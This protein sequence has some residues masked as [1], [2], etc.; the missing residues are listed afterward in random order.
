M[1]NHQILNKLFIDPMRLNLSPY[2]EEIERIESLSSVE[3]K[4]YI[5]ENYLESKIKPIDIF[6]DLFYS[7]GD[8]MNENNENE[9]N[10]LVKYYLILMLGTFDPEIFKKYFSEYDSNDY[11]FVKEE[12]ENKKTLKMTKLFFQILFSLLFSVKEKDIKNT[13][14]E[15]LYN[16]SYFSE[17]FTQYCFGDIRYIHQIYNL[18]YDNNAE[19][20]KNILYIFRNILEYEELNENLMNEILQT[21][22]IVVRCEEILINN[23]FDVD[24]KINSLIL[25]KEISRVV[26]EDSFGKYFENSI[27]T[28]TK[29]FTEEKNSQNETI[30]INFLLILRALTKNSKICNEII[31]K[32]LIKI[33][34]QILGTKDLNQE[35][36]I[37]TL[38][39]FSNLLFETKIIEYLIKYFPGDIVKV[40][41]DILDTY[42]NVV[43]EKINTKVIKELLFCLSNFVTGTQETNNIIAKSD[44]PKLVKQIMKLNQN[45]DAIYIEGINFF[46]NIIENGNKETYTIIS[47]LKPLTIIAYELEHTGKNENI[48]LCLNGIFLVTTKYKDINF[49]LG[50]IKN[51]FYSCA[52]TRKLYEIYYGK[53][54]ELSKIAGQILMIYDNKMLTEDTDNKFG[55]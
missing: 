37:Q 27:N 22:P 15:L 48:E 54:K 44:I 39:I 21:S 34:F 19:M 38:C 12:K 25:M 6:S 10:G 33:L 9:I 46:Y 36:L 23:E 13:I 20:V 17:D 29:I 55:K 53:N 35:Y 24:C 43:S 45:N 28:F 50:E 49:S 1:R 32:G 11:C 16:F 5:I 40:F 41:T 31:A 4:F 26:N 47:E 30:I 2:K 42:M 52:I 51:E 18:M 14:I 8:G 3:N 7:D